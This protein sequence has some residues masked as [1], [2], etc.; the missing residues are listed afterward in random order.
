MH[1]IRHDGIKIIWS[2]VLKPFN[3]NCFGVFQSIYFY[4]DFI[5]FLTIIFCVTC[6]ACIQV[7]V[8]NKGSVKNICF[9]KHSKSNYCVIGIEIFT[10]MLLLCRIYNIQASF[11]R[12]ETNLTRR[13]IKLKGFCT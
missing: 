8:S 3:F 12:R 13:L 6:M 7:F 10:K 9:Q 4:V 1:F 11:I 2:Y 5:Q